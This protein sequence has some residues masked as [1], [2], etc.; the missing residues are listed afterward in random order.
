MDYSNVPAYLS[1]D[2]G[3]AVDNVMTACSNA[4]NPYT[5]LSAYDPETDIASMLSRMVVFEGN[6]EDLD[7]DSIYP[8]ILS[9]AA[10]LVD[11]YINSD[12]YIED[13]VAAHA[14]SLDTDLS[15]KAFPKFEAGMRDINAI[16][17][18]AF[19]IGRAAI[20][21]DRND[22][23]DRFSADMYM[24]ASKDRASLISQVASELLRI[25]I[26]R[27]E[28]H[29]VLASL[30]LD[31]FRIKIAAYADEATENK[32]IEAEEAKFPMAKWQYAANVMAALN[33]GVNQVQASEGNKTARIIGSALSGASAGAMLASAISPGGGNEGYGALMGGILAGI[34]ASM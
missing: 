27:L 21:L 4:S 30:Y 6:V 31:F 2:H 3:T 5:G 11:Q 9:L 8:D 24:Q 20:I 22:K 15:M 12:E 7:W 29:R 32:S 34:G 28:F 10:D 25:F 14:A 18:T 1:T 19:T 33:G 16:Q 17:T 13:R 23:V 26:Q